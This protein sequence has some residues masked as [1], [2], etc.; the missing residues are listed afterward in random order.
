M[1]TQTITSKR[2]QV[3][4]SPEINLV[5][6]DYL[7][8]YRLRLRFADGVVRLVDF[9]PFLAQARNPMATKY[10][11]LAL[12]KTFRVLDGNLNWNDYEMCFP[13]VE[14]YAGRIRL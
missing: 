8:G 7:D 4:P 2:E 5:A 10:R 11:E 12:F 3:A 1:S 14:L 6:A 13:V 9:G